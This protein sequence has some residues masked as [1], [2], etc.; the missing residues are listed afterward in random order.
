MIRLSLLTLPLLIAA[1]FLVGR[2]TSPGIASAK[3]SAHVYTGSFGDVFRVPAAAT[4]CLV[5][6]EAG[7]ANLHCAHTPLARA[8]YEVVFYNDN[9][10]VYRNGHPDYPVF[11]ARGKP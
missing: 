7:A 11:T 1:A 3:A 4:R 5:S 10:F 6:A 2:A 8:R 9:L